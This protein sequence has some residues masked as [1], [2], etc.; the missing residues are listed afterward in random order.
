MHHQ[1]H[2]TGDQPRFE[3]GREV[4]EPAACESADGRGADG[5][6]AL[7][8][9]P[10][11]ASPVG[12]PM[13]VGQ[14]AAAGPAGGGLVPTIAEANLAAA[15]ALAAELAPLYLAT[16]VLPDGTV[17]ALF[18]LIFTR[19]ICLGCTETGYS[20]RF[21]FE[22][23]VLASRRFAELQAED[24]EPAGFIARRGA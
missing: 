19:A 18:D 22:D 9:L 13:G 16:R 10:H 12:G 2:P 23:R 21:C 20:R 5:A 3:R 1:I 7:A 4:M 15:Y 17:A 6:P 11:Y 14:P 24:D 8:T